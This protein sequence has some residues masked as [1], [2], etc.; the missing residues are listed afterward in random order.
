VD[1]LFRFL[2]KYENWVYAALVLGGVFAVRSTWLAWS[3]WRRS[4]YGLEKELALQ[5]VRTSGAVVILL[6]MIGLSLFCMVS[7]VVPFLPGAMFRPTPTVD[8]L[9]T[10]LA[11]L[12]PGSGT[13]GAVTSA[14]PAGSSG[15][16]PGKLIITFPA[17]DAE[18][19]DNITVKGT[20]DMPNF[21][22]FK[23]EFAQQGDEQWTTIGAGN[24]LK[25]DENL[26]SWDPTALPQGDY[27]LRLVVIDNLG[28][29][30]TPCIVP[31]HVIGPTPTP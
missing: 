4:V 20:V 12:N 9:T 27:R 16:V 19:S 30:L 17:P 13:A 10:P 28:N 22:Y 23:Y 7:F 31:V 3:E 2:V 8:L 26:G 5:R 14:P 1:S 15:C 11:T 24:T 29:T 25:H 6:L 21:G 18:I